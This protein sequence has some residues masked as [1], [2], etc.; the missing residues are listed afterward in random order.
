VDGSVL[1]TGGLGTIGA[2]LVLELRARGHRVVACDL[3]HQP[4]QFGISV[5]SDLPAPQYVRCDVGEWREMEAVFSAFRDIRLVYHCAAEFGRW[6]GE[7]YYEKLWTTGAVGTRNVLRLQEQRGFRLV[8]C[9]TSEVYGDWRGVMQESVTERH[10]V[11]LLNDY[12]ISKS[13]N[14]QQIRNSADQHGTQ[15]VIARLFNSYG[16]GEYYSPYRS[17][18]C[19][20]VYCALHGTPWTVRRGHRRT[21]TYVDDT[22]RTLANIADT[23]LPGRVYNIGGGEVHTVERLSEVVLEATGADPALA[24]L[25]DPEPFTTVDKLVDTS[26]AQREIGHRISVSLEEG[27]RRT[28]EWMRSVYPTAAR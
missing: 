10:V 11:R 24:R 8:F 6:N 13:V 27:I 1:V 16:P 9:S 12:A 22:V 4:D 7:D 21:S 3:R 19:R 20:F 14:E 23:F 18:N 28:V 25:A 5:G 26:L 15:S 17:V 2:R